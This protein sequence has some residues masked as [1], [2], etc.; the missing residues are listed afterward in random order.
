MTSLHRSGRRSDATEVFRL[1]RHT[2]VEEYGLEPS[3]AL[4]S[5]YQKIVSHDR[6]DS[7]DS[8]ESSSRLGAVPPRQLRLLRATRLSRML[9]VQP[10]A[11]A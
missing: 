11:V 7:A 4:A 5:T 1:A 6:A 8:A 2:L 10:L 3:H 9:T